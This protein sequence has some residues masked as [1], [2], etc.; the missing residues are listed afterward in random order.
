[1]GECFHVVAT[2][3]PERFGVTHTADDGDVRSAH[4]THEEGDGKCHSGDQSR[5]HAENEHGDQGHD[6]GEGVVPVHFPVMPGAGEV[7]QAEYGHDN[8]GGQG[9]VRQQSECRGEE[10]QGCQDDDHADQ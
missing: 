9:R 8:D 3:R 4:P 6:L 10:E 7:H 2:G 5:F 1:M